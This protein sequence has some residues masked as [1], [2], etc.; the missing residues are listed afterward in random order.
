MK[1][2]SIVVDRLTHIVLMCTLNSCTD[3]SIE[4]DK[5]LMLL[6]VYI[7]RQDRLL[8]NALIPLFN[9]EI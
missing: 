5:L 7:E 6:T 3:N 1:S 9:P 2:L 4:S 8:D